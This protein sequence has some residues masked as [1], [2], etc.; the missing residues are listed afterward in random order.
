MSTFDVTVTLTIQADDGEIAMA[1]VGNILTG[2]RLHKI[3][4]IHFEQ[5]KEVKA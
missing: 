4:D 1:R 3:M 2:T 5:V